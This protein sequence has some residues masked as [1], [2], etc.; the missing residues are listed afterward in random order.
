MRV[1][2]IQIH[3]TNVQQ[4]STSTGARKSMVVGTVSPPGVGGGGWRGG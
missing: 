3:I 1:A 2:Y 4:T